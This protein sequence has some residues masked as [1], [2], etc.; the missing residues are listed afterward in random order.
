MFRKVRSALAGFLAVMM[1]LCAVPVNAEF[2]VEMVECADETSDNITASSSLLETGGVLDRLNSLRTVFPQGYHWNHYVSTASEAGNA[3]D[4]KFQNSITQYECANHEAVDH[5]GWSNA[6]YVGHY[7][8]NYFDGG[9]QCFGFARKVFWEVFKVRVSTL[10]AQYDRQNVRVGDLISY[11][12]QEH[13]AIVLAVNGNNLSVLSGNYD[14]RCSINWDDATTKSNVKCYYRAP[15]YDTIDADRLTEGETIP[16]GTYSIRTLCNTSKALD[17]NPSVA[18]AYIWDANSNDTQKWVIEPVGGYYKIIN[19]QTGLALDVKGGIAASGTQV[20]Q[21]TYNGTSAQMWQ[22]L[23]AGNGNYYIR[24]ALGYYLDLDGAITDNGHKIYVY[25]LNAEG[26]RINQTWHLESLG[27][28]V[29]TP[30]STTCDGYLYTQYND[31][32]GWHAINAE[33]KVGQKIGSIPT[34]DGSGRG[35]VV[36]TER[37]KG[38]DGYWWGKCNYKGVVGW[39]C[40]YDKYIKYVRDYTSP[41]VTFDANGGSVSTKNMKVYLNANYGTLPE[42]SRNG[43]LFAGWYT[44]ANGGSRITQD[45]VVSIESNQTLYAHWTPNVSYTITF[46][47]DGGTGAPAPITA[48]AGTTITISTQIPE[49]YGY[50]F[51]GWWVQGAEGFIAP[52]ATWEIYDDLNLIAYWSPKTSYYISFNAN[53]GTG[54][55]STQSK[56]A[57]ETISISSVQPTRTGYTFVGWSTVLNGGIDYYPGSPYVNDSSVALYAVWNPVKYPIYFN[58]NGGTGAPDTQYQTHFEYL[59]LSSVVPQRAGYTFLGW[60]YTVD[61]AIAYQPGDQF[62]ENRS[63]TLYAAWAPC[64]YT[65]SYDA[66]GGENAPAAQTKRHGQNITITTDVPTRA[67]YTFKGWMGTRESGVVELVPGQVCDYNYSWTFYALW[68]TTFPDQPQVNVESLTAP[69]NIP[70]TVFWSPVKNADWYEVWLLSETETKNLEWQQTNTFY[71]TSLPAG[72]YTFQIVAINQERVNLGIDYANPGFASVT[73][74][75]IEDYIPRDKVEWN[76]HDYWIFDNYLSWG[77]A[78]QFCEALG[79]HLATITSEGEE[80]AIASSNALSTTSQIGFWLGGSDA[81]EE[82]TWKWLTGEDFTYSNWHPEGQPDNAALPHPWIDGLT[83]HENYLM[84]YSSKSPDFITTAPQAYWNDFRSNT[85]SRDIGFICEFEPY[86]V[87]YNANGGE[88]APTN[89]T[90]AHGVDMKLSV[91]VP[92]REGYAFQGWAVSK[93]GEVQYQPGD[94]YVGNANVTLYAVWQVLKPAIRIVNVVRSDG[95]LVCD[96]S[97]TAIPDGSTLCVAAYNGNKM[98]KVFTNTVSEKRLTVDLPNNLTRI[99]VFA[100]ENMSTLKPVCESTEWSFAENEVTSCNIYNETL[101]EMNSSP[102]LYCN[103]NVEYKN[104]TEKSV[105][106]RIVWKQSIAKSCFYGYAQEFTA[107]VGGVS[108]GTVTIIPLNMWG[109][110]TISSNVKSRTVYSD[111]LDIPVTYDQTSVPITVEYIDSYSPKTFAD[112]SFTIPDWFKQ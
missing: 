107:V 62:G 81:E 91:T 61:G 74:K 110:S 50:D 105:Q 27:S 70:F 57:G 51:L 86:V 82:G 17:V 19:A 94:T 106:V 68:E 15:N 9:W 42:P 80:N 26:G 56:Y 39:T 38:S 4:E 47:V 52:G 1:V 71:T 99:K 33:H 35:Y 93:D 32:D 44:S 45:S 103:V 29:I 12:S 69:E 37:V 102:V 89:Q 7:D 41:I 55:P 75:P 76:G 67:G 79:G 43:Y 95:K 90:K 97:L 21:Y 54:V 58:A 100:V 77:T 92:T 13:Y 101:W 96:L 11:A 16:S 5:R 108:T 8:C 34:E 2:A 64:T 83:V 28:S 87:S 46:D 63:V 10:T 22:F 84:I 31:P 111:W 72:N 53:G 78:R 20:Q 23:N 112:A 40:L 14:G 48:L 49:K 73:V 98:I 18:D 65:I 3:C 88:K 60:S 24:S 36:I 59:T 85:S 30:P 66:N 25:D 109:K 104:R 6:D